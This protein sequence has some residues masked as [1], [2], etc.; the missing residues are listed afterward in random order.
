MRGGW[1]T[2]TIL[3]D[4]SMEDN[5]WLGVWNNGGKKSQN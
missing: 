2:K 5:D 3:K 4:N 1:T